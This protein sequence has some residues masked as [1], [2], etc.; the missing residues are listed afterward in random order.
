MAKPAP[1]GGAGGLIFPYLEGQVL[2]EVGGPGWKLFAKPA[3]TG[4]VGSTYFLIGGTATG[5]RGAAEVG[6]TAGVGAA[7][8][9]AIGAFSPKIL[10]LPVS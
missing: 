2:G 3:P 6:T 7:D 5:R 9:A 10:G 8:G 1:T 4:G